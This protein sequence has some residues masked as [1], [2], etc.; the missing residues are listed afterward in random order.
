[1]SVKSLVKSIRVRIEQD[2]A[3]LA[4]DDP[5]NQL[6]QL[7]VFRHEG[8]VRPNLRGAVAQPHR[9]NVPGDHVSVG[10]AIDDLEINRGIERV[11]KTIAK[12]PREFL[13][14]DG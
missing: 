5:G 13:V 14:A 8:Q 10:A 1:M 6:L 7:R 9:V 12:H 3:G 2:A 11:R 4:V